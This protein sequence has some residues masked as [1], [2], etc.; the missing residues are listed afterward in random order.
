[1]WRFCFTR[2]R[3]SPLG[4]K[5]WYHDSVPMIISGFTS[6]TEDFVI[7]S[8]QVTKLSARGRA[9]PV[10]LLQK[11]FVIFVL[12]HTSQFR[13]FRKWVQTLCFLD[14]DATSPGCSDSD[15][16]E[17][18]AGASNSFTW[19]VG[20]SST[21]LSCN[22]VNHSR[23]PANESLSGSCSNCPEVCSS[24]RS[25]TESEDELNATPSPEACNASGSNDSGDGVVDNELHPILVNNPGRNCLFCR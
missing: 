18:C 11:A 9:S 16:G 12:K 14:F 10:R 19:G 25:D 24:R 22:S 17:L 8:D 3:L 15:S 7:C 5:I 20:N 1:M 21:R 4:R 23:I 2:I 13:S 6:L